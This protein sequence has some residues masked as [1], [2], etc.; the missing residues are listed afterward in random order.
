MPT[1]FD[2]LNL[3][4]EVPEMLPMKSVRLSL[5]TLL[6]ADTGSLAPA[7]ANKIA[8]IAAPFTL[9]EGLTA[10]GLTLATFTGSTPIS[11]TSGAQGAGINPATQD[12]LITILTPAGGW[13][14]VCTVAPGAP[15]VIYGFALLDHTLATLLAAEAL[16]TPISIAD[17]DDEI[18]LGA[19][20]M[21]FVLQPLS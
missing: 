3:T 12:Q 19:V 14:W 13:R 7:T 18:D 11:G 2:G 5:G 21:T 16:V 8:L 15:E 9:N 4:Q 1:P 20:T 10:G 6:A 17:V